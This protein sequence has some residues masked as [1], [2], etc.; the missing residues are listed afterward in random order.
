[1]RLEGA[2]TIICPRNTCALSAILGD[3]FA[4]IRLV[5]LMG[6]GTFGRGRETLPLGLSCSPS[7]LIVTVG[8]CHKFSTIFFLNSQ[9][10]VPELLH[11]NP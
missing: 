8:V 4:T 11:Q 6:I 1:M 9:V 10:E 5:N 7:C 2:L 3:P